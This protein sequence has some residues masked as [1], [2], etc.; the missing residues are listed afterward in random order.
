MSSENEKIVRRLFDHWVKGEWAAG[1]AFFADDCE[2]V[3]G[4]S[5]F[6]DAGTYSVGRDALDAW[7]GFMDHFDTFSTGVESIVD[8]GDRVA[9]LVGV[10]RQRRAYR[11]D[12]AAGMSQENV[13]EQ[14]FAGDSPLRWPP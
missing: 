14:P 10:A 1:Q 4:T 7:R 2:V 8:T 9:T 11:W 3:F 13:C 12:A 6:P 5:A